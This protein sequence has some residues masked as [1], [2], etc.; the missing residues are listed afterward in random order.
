MNKK[1][2]FIYNH[3]TS[4]KTQWPW[5]VEI[6]TYPPSMPD[7]STWPKISIITPSYNQAE[8]IEE[9]IRSVIMQGYP[10]LEY[11]IIDGGSTDGSVEIIK[12]YEEY[13]TYW[14]SEPDRGQAHAI[15]KGLS[16]ITGD[17]FGWINSDDLLIKDSLKSL[18]FFHMRNK[19]SIL[20]GN[21]IHFSNNPK[22]TKIYGQK[23]ITFNNVA[24][25]P[26][27]NAIWQQPGTFIPINVIDNNAMDESFR[28]VFDQDWF[29]RILLRNPK[30]EYLA[31]PIAMFR[32]HENSKTVS[33]NELWTEEIMRV[34]FRYW[35]QVPNVNK[36]KIEALIFVNSAGN[37]LRLHSWNKK[38]GI[39]YLNKALKKYKLII[40]NLRFLD[41]LLR[42][43]LSMR[44]LQFFHSLIQYYRNEIS[45]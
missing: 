5:D 44:L 15:N 33:E 26:A 10:N 16:K 14:V 35:D 37:N 18:A 38:Q 1:N 22:F 34:I 20:L 7:G 36:K 45:R 29:C 42:V 6:T 23:N 4:K 27:S 31:F 9:T 17:I 41:N 32:Y 19:K 28:Y 21:V 25:I 30:V 3:T 11:I 40:L 39:F 24:L 43:L 8:F 2:Q 12:K 13:L